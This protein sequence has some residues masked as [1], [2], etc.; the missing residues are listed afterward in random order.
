MA[1]GNFEAIAALNELKQKNLNQ[2]DMDFVT[3]TL[4][5]H[6]KGEALTRHDILRISDLLKQ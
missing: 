3:S 6:E 1:P 5:K 2:A 4:E